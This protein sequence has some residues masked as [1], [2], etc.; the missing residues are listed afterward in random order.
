MVLLTNGQ[1]CTG[2]NDMTLKL[3]D[4]ASGTCVKT[5]IGHSNHVRS[6]VQLAGRDDLT[7]TYFI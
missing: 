2:S 3:W 7:G 5:L 1:L 6:V 4:I